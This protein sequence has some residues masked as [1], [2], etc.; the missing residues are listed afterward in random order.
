MK[1]RVYRASEMYKNGDYKESIQTAL[2]NVDKIKE[3]I[4]KISKRK[5]PKGWIPFN[6]QCEDCGRMSAAKPIMCEYPIIEYKCDCGYKGEVDI[7]KGGVGKLPWRVDWPAR[8]KML[9]VTFEPCGK[10]LATVGGARDTGAKIV[11]EIYGYPHP[12][13]IVY[14]FIL[15][16][17]KGAMHSSKGTA[18]SSEEMLKMTPPEV[19]RFLL[20]KTQPNKHI[21]FDSGLG[22]L[23]LVDEYDKEERAYFGIEEETK[24]MKDLN[25]TYELSQS[26][27]I[28]I[29]I[30]SVSYTHLRAHET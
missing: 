1:P 9:R 2:E 5:L 25:K 12:A 21:V 22:L 19:L 14:E 8:W 28:P 30:P 17:G 27:H 11:E 23:S 13:L 4:E 15:L 10:D 20:M 16:K 26:S 29:T 3:I 24:G 7:R 18:L 6:I